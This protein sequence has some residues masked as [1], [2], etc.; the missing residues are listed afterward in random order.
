[1]IGHVDDEYLVF[2]LLVAV[3]TFAHIVA[4]PSEQAAVALGLLRHNLLGTS[5]AFALAIVCGP[6]FGSLF[7]AEGVAV[8][9]CISSVASAILPIILNGLALQLPILPRLGRDL[10]LET[11]YARV[12]RGGHGD[13]SLRALILGQPEF[14]SALSRET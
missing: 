5:A 4:V 7:G 8:A 12:M 6:L 2:S 11:I 14:V 1:M 13:R 10:R 9:V 3:G